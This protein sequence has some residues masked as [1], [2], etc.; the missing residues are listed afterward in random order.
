MCR[1]A[2]GLL[3][4]TGMVLSCMDNVRQAGTAGFI[5][6]A[7]IISV[8][9]AERAQPDFR[10]EKS[11]PL[12]WDQLQMTTRMPEI[13]VEHQEWIKRFN[14]F[15]QAVTQGKGIEAVDGTLDFLSEYAEAHFTHEEALAVEHHSPVAE[16]NHAN[17]AQFRAQLHELR[18]W[19][20]QG[21][22]SSVEVVAIKQEMEQWLL[23]HICKVDTRILPQ[24]VA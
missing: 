17:H 24:S 4:K 9:A 13:D 10:K 5:I 7:I 14:E 23:N 1:Q 21:G 22:A 12:V 6:H 19:V 20:K 11:M 2:Q 3:E 8:P 18:L 16:L 15:D